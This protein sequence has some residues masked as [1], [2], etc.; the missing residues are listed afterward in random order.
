MSARSLEEKAVE[1]KCSATRIAIVIPTLNES[2]AVGNVLDGVKDAMDGYEYRM[3][4]V[5]GHSIDGTD[6]IARK[7]G[8]EVIY[9]RGRGYGDALKTGFF[10]ARKMLDAGVIVMMDADLSYDPKD[11]PGLVAPILKDEADLV[12]GNR[13][14]GMQKGAM[15]LTNRVGNRLLSWI[16][17]FTFRLNIHDTQCGIRAFRSELLDRMNIVTEGMP[18]ATEMLAEAKRA[19][20][21]IRETPVS[22]R[23]RVGKAKLSPIKDGLRILGTTMRLMRDTHTSTVVVPVL[24][25][26]GAMYFFTVGLVADMIKGFR[27]R[28]EH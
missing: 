7:E 8:A 27:R 17:R 12:V 21:R 26:I 10:H 23:P 20:A 22:Y 6:K 3:L 14:A 16:A 15:R 25:M 13:F 9:Q 2:E 4:V 28:K 1:A 19:D 18:F 24:L 5:D 11:I